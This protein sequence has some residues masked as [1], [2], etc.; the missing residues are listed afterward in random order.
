MSAPRLQHAHG[1]RGLVPATVVA[2]G[3]LTALSV[4]AARDG[5][6]EHGRDPVDLLA[7]ADP[8]VRLRGA[9]R[10]V[11]EGTEAW[12]DDRREVFLLAVAPMAVS[13]GAEHC[14]PPSVTIAQAILESGW[15]SSDKAKKLRNLFGKK[16]RGDEGVASKTW[17]VVDGVQVGTVA[18]FESYDSWAHSL[19][20]HDAHLATDPLY[21][22]AREQRDDAGAFV[23]ALAPT[24]ASDPAYASRIVEIIDMYDLDA[25]DGPAREAAESR[26]RCG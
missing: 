19:A 23:R 12:P 2:V 15:G 21:A 20:D 3:A 1:R 8:A 25:F 17:E 18:R 6:F 14:L 24:Y 26:G 11:A 9:E 16:A 5:A 13:S 10:L 22:R 7:S 4:S